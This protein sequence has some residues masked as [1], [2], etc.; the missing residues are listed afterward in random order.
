MEVLG[1]GFW[2]ARPEQE[3]GRGWTDQAQGMVGSDRTC[4]SSLVLAR[5]SQ[6]LHLQDF[7]KLVGLS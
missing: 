5:E 6:L 2:A 7:C 3:Q 1:Q 4:L